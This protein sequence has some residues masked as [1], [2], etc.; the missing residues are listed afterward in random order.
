MELCLKVQPLKSVILRGSETKTIKTNISLDQSLN[1]YFLANLKYSGREVAC[2][3]GL[4]N[5][6]YIYMKDDN[7]TV[8]IKN[9]RSKFKENVED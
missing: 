3:Y 8:D 9:F 5:V 7:L 1:G 4:K 2:G 6:G